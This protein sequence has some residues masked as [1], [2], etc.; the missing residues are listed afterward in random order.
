MQYNNF[1]RLNI[2]QKLLSPTKILRS[3]SGH[4]IKTVGT[5]DIRISSKTSAVVS[6][7]HVVDMKSENI[8]S[9]DTAEQLG[10]INRL[11]NVTLANVA[12][13]SELL[14]DIKL[15][16]TVK[17][18]TH[19]P[20]RHPPVLKQSQQKKASENLNELP[21][22]APVLRLFDV[23]KPV[24]T[25]ML[26]PD[27]LSRA[28]IENSS[29]VDELDPSIPH[30]QISILDY[31]SMTPEKTAR[32]QETTLR[33]LS[34]L[35]A[36]ILNGWPDDKSTVP[37]S[38]KPFYALRSELSVSDGLIFK[39]MRIVVPP[40]LR[41]EMLN[42]IHQTHLGLGKC[43]Q[44]AREVLYWPSMNSDI[45]QR[46]QNCTTCAEYGNQQPR[47]PLN[48]SSPPVLPYS[49]IAVNSCQYFRF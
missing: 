26:L 43:K 10:L 28:F 31:V 44:R 34:D 46:I 11:C 13:N 9:G 32:F 19:A 40:S 35:H 1:K 3:F 23:N 8:L 36:V 33:E 15:N 20:S 45:E 25:T 30:N 38:V 17:S 18:F 22:N 48:P 2:R 27:T 21:Y 12:E 47:A 5:V 29:S 42:R 16:S 37:F 4:F 49:D 24:E 7:F 41:S 14:P 39:G 6:T